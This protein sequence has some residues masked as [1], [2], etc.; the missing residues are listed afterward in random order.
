MPV[1][2][3]AATPAFLHRL[4][5]SL[6]TSYPLFFWIPSAIKKNVVGKMKM[7][8]HSDTPAITPKTRVKSSIIE[9]LRPIATR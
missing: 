9:A 3:N 2:K 4:T 8:M 1:I 6:P 5:S 7:M